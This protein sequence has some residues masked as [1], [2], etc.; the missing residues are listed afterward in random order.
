MSCPPLCHA[1]C[2][3]HAYVRYSLLTVFTPV[4]LWKSITE[5]ADKLFSTLWP[6]FAKR[7]NHEGVNFRFVAYM[8]AQSN[9]LWHN[10]REQLEE[11]V[12]LKFAC[13]FWQKYI[14]F[15]TRKDLS[16]S[17]SGSI[18]NKRRPLHLIRTHQRH[19]DK[20]LADPSKSKFNYFKCSILFLV[21]P[22]L[23]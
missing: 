22:Y 21:M 1:H 14:I 7:V 3:P 17:L 19:G 16:L 2:T 20:V 23:L 8:L 15:I 13:T 12:S 11:H 9:V 18:S 6:T 10:V 4:V 5:Y